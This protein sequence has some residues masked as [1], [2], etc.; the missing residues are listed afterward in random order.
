MIDQLMLFILPL[1]LTDMIN[2]ILFVG[3][4]YGLGSQKHLLNGTLVLFSFFVC[5]FLTGLILAEGVE[6]LTQVLHLSE[7]WDYAI[8]AF[9]AI[10]LL[11]F[12][13]INYKTDH[14]P[15]L[16]L[17]K[18]NELTSRQAIFLGIHIHLIGLPFA[19]PYLA[20]IDQILKADISYGV[21][22]SLILIY[23]VIYI[24]PFMLL[25]L[26]RLFTGDRSAF[27]FAKVNQW[28]D[29]VSSKVIP[30]LFMLLGLLLL[31]DCLSYF[32]GYRIYSFLSLT[33][34]A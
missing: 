21:I 11:Y 5:Y 14:T 29:W 18:K 6:Y 3:V 4:V 26:I 9:V 27:L 8:E 22:F 12:G 15:D 7:D 13:W 30:I 17:S 2:P 31:E 24:L 25:I 28:L 16:H 10:L 19:V 32:L 34:S 23:N 20:A 33:R 1:L